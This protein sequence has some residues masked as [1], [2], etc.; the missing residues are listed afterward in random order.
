MDSTKAESLNPS[1][2][3]RGHWNLKWF[4]FWLYTAA[5]ATSSYMPLQE[6]LNL[7]IAALC[8]YRGQQKELSKHHHQ[9]NKQFTTNQVVDLNKVFNQA[10]LTNV[11]HLL[12][13]WQ[14]AV[15]ICRWINRMKQTHTIQLPTWHK[16]MLSYYLFAGTSKTPFHRIYI[17]PSVLPFLDL[18]I[19]SGVCFER[20]HPGKKNLDL[21]SVLSYLRRTVI[22]I[23]KLVFSYDSSHL[24]T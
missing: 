15:R 22:Y 18:G 24:T 2:K 14:R 12:S 4:L 20:M 21:F 5:L 7:Y 11:Q 13:Y 19:T 17:S 23:S 1:S 8:H 16:I 9:S 3:G 10:T 6:I